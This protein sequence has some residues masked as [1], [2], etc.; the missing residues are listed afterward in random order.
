MY[1]AVIFDLDNCLSAAEAVGQELLEPVFATIR[2]H[3]LGHFSESDMTAII[4]DLWRLP[5]DDIFDKY[6]F[7]QA[8]RD[9][10]WNTYSQLEV[11][12]PMQAY[13]DIGILPELPVMRF[14]VTTGFRRF[15]ES[16]IRALGISSLFTEIRVD[17]ID[18]AGKKG[19]QNHF[20]DIMERRRLRPEEVMVVGDNAESEIVAGNNLGLTTVQILRPGVPRGTNADHYIEGLAGLRRLLLRDPKAG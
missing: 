16:K 7:P 18:E 12:K 10:T 4:V 13:D 1:K 14:L 11:K 15:Q 3:S 9:A 19:K 5:L 2:R 6:R 20:A 17:A 8:T